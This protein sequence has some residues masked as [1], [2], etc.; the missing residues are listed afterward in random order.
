MN[1][2]KDILKI[3][4]YQFR[5]QMCSKRVWLGYLLGIVIIMKQSFGYFVYADSLK[6]PVNVLEAFVVAGNNY[7][8]A[9]FLILG[10]LLVISEAPFVNSISFYLIYRT[11]K[12]NWNT[13]MI[14]YIFC[15][16]VIYYS[17]IVGSTILFSLKN[18]FF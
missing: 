8:T 4:V 14:L 7:N 18:S 5:I 12:K 3:C 9:M 6:E 2:M 13:A 10:W 1:K 15:Q 16:A 11:N 17:L